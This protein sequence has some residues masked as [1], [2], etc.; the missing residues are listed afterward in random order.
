[1]INHFDLGKYIHKVI[2]MKV[3]K[4]KVENSSNSPKRN[5][6]RSRKF[7]RRKPKLE[8]MPSLFKEKEMSYNLQALLM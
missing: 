7:R 2:A 8:G 4:E 3:E 6:Q 5:I 1:M